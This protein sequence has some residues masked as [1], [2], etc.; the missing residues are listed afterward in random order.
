M[1][2]TSLGMQTD[3]KV[4]LVLVLV[5]VIVIL[6]SVKM[7]AGEGL[8]GGTLS[9]NVYDGSRNY[10]LTSNV[11]GRF[12]ETSD[13]IGALIRNDSLA[14]NLYKGPPPEFLAGGP[15]GYLSDATLQNMLG[16]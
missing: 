12:S 10:A 6:L 15:K 16:S 11:A 8:M 2:W 3:T 1:D 13:N 7:F 5:L 9:E 14:A 4:S